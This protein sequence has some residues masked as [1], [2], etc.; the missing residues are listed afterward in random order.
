MSDPDQQIVSAIPIDR[1]NDRT[2]GLRVRF[3]RK[4]LGYTQTKVARLAKVSQSV[5]SLI[6]TNSC[7]ASIGQL[8]AVCTAL[9]I[10]LATIVEDV[11]GMIAPNEYVFT[12]ARIRDLAKAISEISGKSQERVS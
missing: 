5:V 4:K 8:M 6:E 12:K 3:Y 1:L 7:D 10:D 2:V 11:P 9:G